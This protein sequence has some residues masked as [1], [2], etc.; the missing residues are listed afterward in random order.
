[1]LAGKHVTA[2]AEIGETTETVEAG[3]SVRDLETMFQLVHLEITA[4][5]KDDRAIAVWRQNLKEQLLNRLRD[6]EVQFQIQ[7]Q[8]VARIQLFHALPDRAWR[9]YEAQAQVVV[10]RLAVEW[11]PGYWGAS[12]EGCNM[13]VLSLLD[14]TKPDAREPGPKRQ[15]HITGRRKDA[16]KV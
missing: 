4:P 1:M 14:W 2:A 9:R 13:G 5:R 7:S 6:P 15:K 10:D 12:D 16:E 3:A 11:R 8:A